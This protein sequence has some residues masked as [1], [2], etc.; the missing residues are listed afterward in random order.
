MCSGQGLPWHVHPDGHALVYSLEG[1]FAF[2]EQN[3]TKSSLRPG[4]VKHI[5]PDV[6]HTVRNEGSTAAKVLV[7]RVKEKTKPVAVLFQR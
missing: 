5:D 2:E 1:T 6:G 7:I 3:G 4:E